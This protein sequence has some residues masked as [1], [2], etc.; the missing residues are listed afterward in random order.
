MTRTERNL[1]RFSL[2]VQLGGLAMFAWAYSLAP[3]GLWVF[4]MVW[5]CLYG[6]LSLRALGRGE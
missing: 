5:N 3:S 2:G 4:F 6:A 1:H